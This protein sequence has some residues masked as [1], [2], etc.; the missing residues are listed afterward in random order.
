MA[1]EENQEKELK[2]F[3]K[4]QEP[5]KLLRAIRL[6]KKFLLFYNKTCPSCKR[7]LLKTPSMLM[8]EYCDKCQRLAERIIK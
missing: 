4:K 7:K 6:R 1:K 8:S 5:N 2:S 3:I